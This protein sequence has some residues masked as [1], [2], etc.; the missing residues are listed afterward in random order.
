[1]LASRMGIM[2]G[3]HEACTHGLHS[4]IVIVGRRRHPNVFL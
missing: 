2:G 4:S 1:M 3:G